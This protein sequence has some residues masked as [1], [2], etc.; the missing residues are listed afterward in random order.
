MTTIDL[1]ELQGR[2]DGADRVDESLLDDSAHALRSA[3]PELSTPPTG[4]REPTDG[5]L[6]L[7]DRCLP[8]WTIVLRGT[9]TEPDGHWTCHLRR[10][11]IRDDDAVIGRGAA[12][13]VGLA[14]LRALIDAARQMHMAAR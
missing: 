6:W 11:D 5:A 10:S 13:R 1:T 7:I 2:V 4:Q 3:F 14:M 9:A 12:P 8:G